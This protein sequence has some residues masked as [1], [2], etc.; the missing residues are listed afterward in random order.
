MTTF[1]HL[2]LSMPIL[3]AIK[4]K[5][6]TQATPIQAQAIPMILS[7][8]DIFGS[9]RT[10]TGKT[11]AFAIPVLQLMHE[12]IN[13]SKK[14][15]ALILAPTRELAHQISESVSD[16][17]RN[18]GLR[19]AVIYGGVSQRPQVD[20]LRRGCDIVIATPGRLLDLI[21]QGFIRLNHIEFLILDEADRMLDRGF[22][23]DIRR[24]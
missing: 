10:G 9:A 1:E 12:R 6:Y 11:A 8:K 13:G 20:A 21:N 19:H 7:G 24:S 23:N 22:I 3:Q 5:G 14:I 18:T 2:N 4:S 16:Y 17:G 15:K